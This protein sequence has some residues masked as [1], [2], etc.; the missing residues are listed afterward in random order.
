MIFIGFFMG[1]YALR[2]RDKGRFCRFAWWI[3]ICLLLQVVFEIWSR[4]NGV[5]S[6]ALEEVNATVLSRTFE[7]AFSVA[8]FGFQLALIICAFVHASQLSN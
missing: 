1:R 8:V 2:T 5:Y 3:L 6:K 4:T 7:I